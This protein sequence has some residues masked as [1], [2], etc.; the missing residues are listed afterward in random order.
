MH[1]LLPRLLA[2]NKA[3][4]DRRFEV[5]ASAERETTILLYD[6]IV[7]TQEQADWWGGVAADSFVKTV[8]ALDADVIHLR[9][10][11]PGGD[12]FAARAME[13]A[14]RQHKA[15]IHVH[16]DGVAAS[17]ASFL[18]LAGDEIAIAQ[19]GFV[20]I[21]QASTFAWGNA[22]DLQ[23]SI[24]LLRKVDGSQL[25]SFEA[26]TGQSREQLQAWLSAE[27]WFTASEAVSL[28]FA[29]KIAESAPKA[30]ASWDLSAYA[31]APRLEPAP[32]ADPVDDPVPHSDPRARL[33]AQADLIAR[34]L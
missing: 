12:V 33:R 31:N 4:A 32:L 21:H 24:D 11:S 16:I 6:A 3:V 5:V 15:K 20:M 17:A 22:D 27:T 18:M 14:L 8:A 28:G 2:R 23:A 10:N 34:E 13:T 7:A 26:A 19:G 25:D 1:N 9:I 30:T 29:H